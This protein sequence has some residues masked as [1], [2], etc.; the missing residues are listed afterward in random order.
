LRRKLPRATI[1]AGFWTLK[2]EE[3]EERNALTATGADLVAVSLQQAV[4]H[5]IN[6]V[7]ADAKDRLNAETQPLTAL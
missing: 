3:A 7:E 4:E 1:V 6:A 5:V 2:R